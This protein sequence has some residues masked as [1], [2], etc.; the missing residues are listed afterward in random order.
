MLLNEVFEPPIS[1]FQDV[2]SDNSK[3]TY[4][5]SRKTKLTLKQIRKL[6]RMLDVR[7]YEESEY[8]EQVRT[9][10]GPKPDQMGG[11]MPGF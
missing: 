3:P 6:R 9:Q 4:K 5:S 1:G 7:Q 10:Y 2:N 8:L 11:G